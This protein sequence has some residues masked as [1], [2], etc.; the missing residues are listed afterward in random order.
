MK[1]GRKYWN[2]LRTHESTLIL[3]FVR[4]NPKELMWMMLASV[5]D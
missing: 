5:L 1:A 2:G 3:E 4:W